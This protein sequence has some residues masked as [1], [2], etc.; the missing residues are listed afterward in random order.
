MRPEPDDT[1]PGAVPEDHNDDTDTATT[2]ADVP[3]EEQLRRL[4]SAL[5]AEREARRAA[6]RRLADATTTARDEGINQGRT[7]ATMDMGRRLAGA[8]FRARSAGRVNDPAAALDLLDLSRMVGADGE[9]DMD[10]IEDAV[11]R[12]VAAIPKPSTPVA[13]T[14]PNG[15]RDY[16]DTDWLRQ[17]LN[18]R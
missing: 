14:V 17:Q 8:E 16:V 9:P 15:A 10:A 4:E 6:E 2:K 18:R 5:H 3:I 13:P 7:S 1:T 12:L 11:A